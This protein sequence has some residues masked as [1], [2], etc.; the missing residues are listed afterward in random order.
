VDNMRSACLELLKTIAEQKTRPLFLSDPSDLSLHSKLVNLN[1]LVDDPPPKFDDSTWSAPGAA[2]NRPKIPDFG[3]QCIFT[4]NDSRLNTN[5]SLLKA[6]RCA[7]AR[8]GIIGASLRVM[9][10]NEYIYISAEV[11]ASMRPVLYQ[12][13]I[14]LKVTTVGGAEAC[15]LDKMWCSCV[16]GKLCCHHGL[17]LAFVSATI[18]RTDA[19]SLSKAWGAVTRA[20]KEITSTTP[21]AE[22]DVAWGEAQREL[23]GASTDPRIRAALDTYS[24]TERPYDNEAVARFLNGVKGRSEGR[25]GFE[26]IWF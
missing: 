4:F 16:S 23:L 8:G 7:D 12:V 14:K 9:R 2:A 22:L 17:A 6:G 11:P 5:N 3:K 21:V 24:V 19:T 18:S 10:K 25:K 20:G 26:H 1:Y 15:T 13:I